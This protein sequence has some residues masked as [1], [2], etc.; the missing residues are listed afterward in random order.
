MIN[1]AA[2]CAFVAQ[3]LSV[4]GAAARWISAGDKGAGGAFLVP[5]CGLGWG[6]AVTPG[7]GDGWAPA[8][9]YRGFPAPAVCVKCCSAPDEPGKLG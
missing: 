8:L 5:R 9:F 4:T 6:T 3:L 7:S 1:P 2:P